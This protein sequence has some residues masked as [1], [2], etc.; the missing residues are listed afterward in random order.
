VSWF[1]GDEKGITCALSTVTGNE[2]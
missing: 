2:I 1:C